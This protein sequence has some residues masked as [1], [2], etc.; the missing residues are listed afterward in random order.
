MPRSIVVLITG[1]TRGL[2][3]AM[4]GEFA[5]LGDPVVGCGRS[6]AEIERLRQEFGAPHD[7][8]AVDVARDDDVQS[9]ASLVLA[10]H[11]PPDLL[12]NNAGVI[13]RNA[14]LW[15]LGA[16]EFA[17]VVEVNLNGTAN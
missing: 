7:F 9:W 6:G 8:Y 11:G 5:R 3:R 13:N 10:A 12:L 17:A 2:G 4:A 1:V 14:P 15:E 16:R